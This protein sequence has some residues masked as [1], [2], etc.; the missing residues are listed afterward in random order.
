MEGRNIAVHIYN[1]VNECVSDNK[2]YTVQPP[3]LR[4]MGLEHGNTD[5]C[6][7]IGLNLVLAHTG[8]DEGGMESP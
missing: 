5:T 8:T 1:Q 3:V 2:S 6:T 4:L 7:Y